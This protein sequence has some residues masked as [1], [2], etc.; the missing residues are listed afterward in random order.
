M[1]DTLTRHTFSR[2]HR[3][4]GIASAPARIIR[5]GQRGFLRDFY[6]SARRLAVQ[7][8]AGFVLDPRSIPPSPPLSLSLFLIARFILKKW[9]SIRRGRDCSLVTLLPA[10]RFRQSASAR[11]AI[12]RRTSRFIPDPSRD[13]SSKSPLPSG[14]SRARERPRAR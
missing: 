10:L 6:R 13:K 9:N 4:G 1:R 14:T 2:R 5:E 11:G 12:A 8:R 7:P 3:S